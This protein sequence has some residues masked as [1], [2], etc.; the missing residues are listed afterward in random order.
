MRARIAVVAVMLVLS[1]AA[2]AGCSKAR[3]GVSEQTT[4]NTKECGGAG[5]HDKQVKAQAASVHETV[6][7]SACHPGSGSAHAKSPKGAIAGT[8]WRVDSCK[9]CHTDEVTTYLYDDNAQAGPFGGSITNPPQPK[10]AVFPG[11]NTIIAGHPF[12]KDY[13]EEGAHSIM[14]EEHFKT[15]RGKFD[16]C[17]QCKSTKVALAWDTGKPLTVSADTTVTLTHTKTPEAPAKQVLIPKG[18]K[19]VYA[20]D[21]ITR[22]VES[23]M[24]LPDGSSFSSK[25]LPSEDATKNYNMMWAGTI[26]AIRDTWPYGAGCNHCHDPHTGETRYVRKAMLESIEGTGGIK[27]TGGINPY[28]A[29]AEKDIAKASAKDRRILTCTQCHVE[30]TCGKSSVD[31][32]ERDAYGWAKAG[33]LDALYMKQFNYTQD[34]KQAIIGQTLIKSQHPETELY[35]ESVHYNAGASCGDCHMPEITGSDGKRFRSHWFTSPFKLER[36]DLV[37]RFESATGVKVAVADN[38]CRRCH[39]D[40]TAR[41]IEQQQTYFA[42]QKVVEDLLVQSVNT[43]GRVKA[44]KDASA[45]IE[46]SAYAAAISAHRKAH[47]LWENLAVS[48]NS[49]GFHNF[50][51]VMASMD[52]AEKNAREAIANGNAALGTK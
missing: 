51:E 28:A 24:T 36:A 31:G 40:R 42:R 13:N 10:S 4:M 27:G 9:P 7:C 5:C 20:T 11:Y 46:A 21:K 2:L 16:T 43:L 8:D 26:A 39:S 22:R 50:E 14:L 6:G 32:I 29:T 17:V 45:S 1:A 18:T 49:M 19:I 3:V 44:A 41:A 25:P 34:W 35:W 47:V 38:P 23:K 37:S 48:E 30:Y 12:T 33:D 15:L 52:T